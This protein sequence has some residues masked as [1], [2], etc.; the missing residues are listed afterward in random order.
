MSDSS[1][2]FIVGYGSL[3]SADS[4]QRFSN[5]NS[6]A[7]PLTLNGWKRAWHTRS[8]D[9]NQ[10]YVGAQPDKK[11]SLNGVLLEIDEISPGLQK[12]EQDYQFIE[13]TIEEIDF[14]LPED[15]KNVKRCEVSA[16]SIW[17][18]QTLDTLPANE[19]HPVY[20][21][22]IDTCLLGCLETEVE[23]FVDAFIKSTDLWHHHW[24]NDRH[25]PR[26]PRAAKIGKQGATMIDTMLDAMQVLEH[27]IE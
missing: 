18:C 16:H 6:A 21:S 8:T 24:L 23:G 9:E 22:Y 3:L 26:Y 5:I 11:S 14:H 15:Q 19:E 20:Q 25:D 17:V 13:V 1:K 7:I 12:R 10:T 4:R 27:R 2:H